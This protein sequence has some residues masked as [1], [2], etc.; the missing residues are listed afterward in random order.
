M[1]RV[2]RAAHAALILAIVVSAAVLGA[3]RPV[4]RLAST[5]LAAAVA[6]PTST[7]V[8][9]E[10]M[11]G[12]ASAS[13]EFAE[14]S[15][16]GLDPV[17]LTGYEVVYVTSTG[18]T[19]TRKASW[20]A[21]TIVAPGRHLLI[22]N[23]S[24]VYAA[25]ADVTYSGGLAATGG[26]IVLRPIGGSPADAVGWGD[27]ANTFVEGA[28]ASA[29]PAGSS[30]E[31]LPGG[32][33]GNGT[34]TNDNAADFALRGTPTP[35][36]L[37]A[38]PTPTP[39]SGPSAS[40]TLAPTPT[41]SPT[42]TSTPSPTTTPT[43]TP[44]PT[45]NPSLSPSPTGIPTPTPTAVPTPTPTPTTAPTTTPSPT[46][47][48]SPTPSPTTS[49]TPSPVLSID[50]ARLLPDGS[51]A[52]VGGTLTTALGAL[53]A[54]R[55]GFLQDASSGIAIR[56][57]SSLAVAIPAGA[58]VQVTGSIA[59]YFSLRTIN[60]DPAS[61]AVGPFS[62]LPAPAS[63]ATGA[64]VE[65]AEGRRV[66]VGGRVTETP[67]ELADGLGVMIDDGSGSLRIVVSPEA[68]GAAT[69]ATGDVVTAVGPLGQ[70]DS[71]GTGLSGYR[72]HVT[73]P[74]EFGV[75][76]PSPSPSLTPTP[77]PA[78]SQTSS[79]APSVAPPPTPVPTPSPTPFV[80]T[81][82]IA[83][84]R[85]LAPGTI[86][87]IGGVVTA[88]S[89]RLGTPSLIA[90][91]DATGGIVIKVPE[92]VASPV[93][94]SRIETRGQLTDPY[95]QL[96]VRPPVAGFRNLGGGSLPAPHAI[97]AA[98]L[99]ESTEARL[100]V[101]SGVVEARPTRST[102]GD[103]TMTLRGPAGSIRVLADASSG[104]TAD[105]VSVAWTYEVV[106][107]GGQR[108][109]RKGALDGYRLW[110]RDAAD[111]VR[112]AGPTVTPGA[113]AS[114]SA[115]GSGGAPASVIP[116]ADAVRLGDAHVAVEGLV[117]TGSDLL[118]T[119]G[120]RIV[121]EDRTAGIEVLIAAGSRPPAIGTRVRVEGAIGRAYD[122]PRIRADRIDVI[123]VGARPLPIELT[124]P[125]TAAHEWRLVRVRGTIADVH[126]LGD[127]WRAEIRIGSETV[128]ISGVAGARIPSSLLVEGRP[129]SIVGVVR[130]PNPAATDRRWA[131]MPRSV[132]DV[133]VS[134]GAS[135]ANGDR[136][137]AGPAATN[138]ATDARVRDVDLADLA[139]H[140]GEVVRVGGLVTELVPDGFLLDD[141]TAIGRV[142]LVGDAAAYQS[143]LEPG[144]ALNAIGRVE[145][146]DA[147][148]RVVVADPAGLVRVGAPTADGPL[149]TA[150]GEPAASLGAPAPPAPS[151]LAGGLLGYDL[152]S[153]GL[154]G[155]LL[156]SVAS[157]AVTA[158]RRLRARR[159]LAA[160]M[161]ARLASV[162]ATHG[163]VR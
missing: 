126:K 2:R 114:A 161:A 108:A 105:S 51:V 132:A 67:S 139:G 78:P 143:L 103:I 135:G 80:V 130:R 150:S 71:S 115:A 125:P 102:S 90:I 96:E 77:T 55:I 147:G 112:V 54:G 37:A 91:Q 39:S 158:L 99:G 86:V 104:L 127:R 32:S 63:I 120:R 49:P 29:P 153:A 64:A 57:D 17:D 107:I 21:A 76:A 119:T 16:T 7:L 70:R 5:G 129:A 116:I 11:T 95:G 133:V 121:I 122:A 154:V 138:A 123:A 128:L 84:A 100:I 30:I 59:S 22:A 145:H 41:P 62:D 92:G 155:I 60:V 68:L 131:V 8:V 144:D 83:D 101:V 79:P 58:T 13:D 33:L 141:G 160:R 40:A 140:V 24:G 28:A 38:D 159:A 117:T 10:V 82:T 18:G 45:P 74:G 88:E 109:S 89:G 44:T 35:Q 152:G 149:D 47:T 163:P 43:P 137:S 14:L 26:A 6:W 56:L 34:D 42:A 94:G 93:R 81:S 1:D 118:D 9:S 23:G 27:A 113:S 4:D 148:F 48:T 146:D 97:G 98:P 20:A 36:N 73:L 110:T 52:T 111:L 136:T 61:L 124:R 65:T 75:A 162:T 12:G 15:N 156:A 134:G 69:V 72:V 19:I 50:E 157:V 151:S 3:G 85:R 106:G 46:A 66:A 31:R 87:S 25:T 53:E 142:A